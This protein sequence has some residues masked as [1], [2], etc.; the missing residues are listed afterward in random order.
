MLHQINIFIHVLSGTIALLLGFVAL[1]SVK[2]GTIHNR[3]GRFFLIFMSIV[4]LTGLIGVFGYGRNVFLLVITV[5][6]GYVAFSGYRILQFRSNAPRKIDIAIALISLL[7][8]IYYLFYFKATDMYWSPILIYSTTGALLLVITYDLFRFVIPR[9][10]YHKQRIWL[11]EHI[12][13]MT[14]AFTGL[15]AAF[16]GTV[17]DAYQPHSQYL[18]S[19]FGILLIIGFF[20]YLRKYGLK[21]FRR[22]QA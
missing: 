13:K 5:L 3:S 2:G 12:Y 1:S 18:P 20:L 22:N 15:L 7:I 9:K 14:S 16:S 6:S 19:L 17:F 11:Y 8:L 21:K 10:T 4:I